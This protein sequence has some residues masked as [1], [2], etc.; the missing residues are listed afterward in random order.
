MKTRRPK[1]EIRSS[2]AQ[3]EETCLLVRLGFTEVPARQESGGLSPQGL[4]YLKISAKKSF[5][6]SHERLSAFSL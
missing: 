6:S 1:C 2:R 5:M 4:P 3:H